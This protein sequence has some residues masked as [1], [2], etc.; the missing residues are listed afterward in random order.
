ML[1][2]NIAKN[3]LGLC[4]TG[5]NVQRAGVLT[6]QR[7]TQERHTYRDATDHGVKGRA[8]LRCIE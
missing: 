6:P 8:A 7:P 3:S 1:T 5:L 4:R 2:H